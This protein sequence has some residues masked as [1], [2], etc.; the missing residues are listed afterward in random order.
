MVDIVGFYF[1]LLISLHPIL[2][3]SFSVILKSA[4]VKLYIFLR[5]VSVILVYSTVWNIS[6][7]LL[8]KEEARDLSLVVYS[9]KCPSLLGYK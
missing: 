2:Y 5:F 8:R 9:S 6:K 4:N 3:R 7:R 1:P